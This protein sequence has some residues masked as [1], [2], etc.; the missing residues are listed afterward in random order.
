[1]ISASYTFILEMRNTPGMLVRVAQ[2][3]GRRGANITQVHVNPPSGGIFSKM[4][5]TATD[6]SSVEQITRQ[7]EKLID[8]HSVTVINSDPNH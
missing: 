8:I 6:V 1:M 3:F 2:I 4:S 7:L 5:I